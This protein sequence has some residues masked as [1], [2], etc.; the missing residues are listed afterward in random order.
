MSVKIRLERQGKKKKPY[1]HIVISDARA[2]R[3]GKFIERIGNYNPNV[4]PARIEI[5]E[6]KALEWL[7]KGAQPTE[8]AR[9]ILSYKGILL[10][11]HLAKG[12]A[13]GALTEAEAEKKH[14][15][16]LAEQEKKVESKKERLLKESKDRSKIQLDSESKRKKRKLKVFWKNN[17][18][19]LQKQKKH[20]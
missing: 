8:T 14:K 5:D 2:P 15:A 9:A 19:W 17:L 6:E 1:Y 12:V 3:D 10:K 13:K 16:W 20:L 11:R 7:Q 4:N 18:Y